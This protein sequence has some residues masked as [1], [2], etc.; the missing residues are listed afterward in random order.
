[1]KDRLDIY[2]DGSHLD[3]QNNGRLGIGGVIVDMDV[4]IG[5]GNILNEFSQELIPEYMKITFGADKCS[6]PSAELCALLHALYNIKK[7][8]RGAKKIVVHADYMGVREWMTG[9]WKIKEPYIMRIKDDIDQ[10]IYNQGLRGRIQYEWVRG[11]Q[12]D[13]SNDTYWNNYVDKLAKGEGKK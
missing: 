9:N 3:K 8:I 6:N 13:G 10:E 7:E 12:T 5:H 1:M 4:K 11:H 2:I